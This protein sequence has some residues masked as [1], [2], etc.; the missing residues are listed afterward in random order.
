VFVRVDT[1]GDSGLTEWLEQ[2]G[3]PRVDTVVRMV[4][5]AAPESVA[6]KAT[7]CVQYGI[8]NQAIF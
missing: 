3:L 2:L 5:N 6:A 1:P 4:R 7:G 8:V